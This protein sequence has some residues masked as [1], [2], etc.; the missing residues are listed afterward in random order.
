MVEMSDKEGKKSKY[1]AQKNSDSSSEEKISKKKSKKMLKELLGK[2]TLEELLSKLEEGQNPEDVIAKAVQS[3]NERNVS[4]SPSPRPQRVRERK[5]HDSKRYSHD[6]SR[7]QGKE[8]SSRRAV[9]SDGKSL[10]MTI[11]R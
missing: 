8:N 4:R 7:N 10:K 3:K 2:D 5:E 9:V 11:D 1:Q 6:E